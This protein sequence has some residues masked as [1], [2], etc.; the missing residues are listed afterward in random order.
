MEG[1]FAFAIE[2]EV[3][4]KSVFCGESQS[5]KFLSFAGSVLKQKVAWPS[6]S[7]NCIY[8]HI[9]NS[10][11]NKVENAKTEKITVFSKNGLG[12]EM[13]QQIGLVSTGR[14][15]TKCGMELVVKVCRWHK[16]KEISSK[17]NQKV[18]E[19]LQINYYLEDAFGFVIS[20]NFA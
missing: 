7:E 13:V 15:R 1:G 9:W 8:R 10:L 2:F 6:A 12:V 20:L 4:T 18:F 14:S 5:G 17:K 11:F 3:Q 19:Y 16:F